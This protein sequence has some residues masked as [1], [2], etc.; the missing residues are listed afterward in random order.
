MSRWSGGGAGERGALE[1]AEALGEGHKAILVKGADGAQGTVDDT[2]Q[3]GGGGGEVEVAA[4]VALVEQGDDLVA[5]LETP[6]MLAD[7]DDLASA[8]GS[9]DDAHVEGKG[10]LALGDDEVTVLRGC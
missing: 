6:H 9:R 4:D 5:G 10:V 2:A 7:G 1:E 8:V 3:A